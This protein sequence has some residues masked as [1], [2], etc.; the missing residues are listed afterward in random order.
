MEGK[1][2]VY[3]MMVQFFISIFLKN[4][5]LPPDACKGRGPKE[6][7]GKW[8]HRSMADHEQKATAGKEKNAYDIHKFGNEPA[9]HHISSTDKRN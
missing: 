5:L 4:Y 9:G 8:S 3:L 2:K 6:V 7:Q 1:A